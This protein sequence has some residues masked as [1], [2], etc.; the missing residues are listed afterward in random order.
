MGLKDTVLELM[1]TR[2]VNKLLK[3][4]KKGDTVRY[5]DIR[6]S[7]IGQGWPKI[8]QSAVEVMIAMHLAKKC[9]NGTLEYL[10]GLNSTDKMIFCEKERIHLQDIHI[11]SIDLYIPYTHVGTD[12]KEIKTLPEHLIPIYRVK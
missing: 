4:M 7:V 8:D 11:E 10:M 9:E 3:L 6:T 1:V 2:K 5:D 12:G